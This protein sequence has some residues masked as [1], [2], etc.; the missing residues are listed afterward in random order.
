[1]RSVAVA[2]LI[3]GTVASASAQVELSLA[4]GNGGYDTTYVL[5]YTHI[6]TGRL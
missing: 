2:I 6:L 3:L 1:M 5:D 4:A